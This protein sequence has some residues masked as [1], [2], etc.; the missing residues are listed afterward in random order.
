MR[1]VVFIDLG[2]S[3]TRTL[4]GNAHVVHVY[5]ET[6]MAEVTAAHAT[7]TSGASG[8]ASVV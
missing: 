7:D 6:G 3:S 8:S 4:P 2:D 5:S 1:S